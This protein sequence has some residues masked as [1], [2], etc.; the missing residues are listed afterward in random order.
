LAIRAI[1]LDLGPVGWGAIVGTVV[2]STVLAISTSMAGIARVG[3]TVTSVLLTAEV[4]LAVTWA[5]LLGERLHA[6][7]AVGGVL[8]VAA[9]VLLQAGPIRRPAWASARYAPLVCAADAP[10]R[11]PPTS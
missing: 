10:R 8:V 1:E 7:Q 6:V 11:P 3:P 9:V 4:P 2:I 5:I